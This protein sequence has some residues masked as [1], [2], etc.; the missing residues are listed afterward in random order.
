M[1]RAR[2]LTGMTALIT[3]LGPGPRVGYAPRMREEADEGLMSRYAAGDARAFEALYDRWRGPLY[4]YF[5]RHVSTDGTAADLYQGCWEKVINAR[6]R[7]RPEIPFR[8]WLFR[9]A[10]NHL[11]DHYRKGKPEI[12]LDAE[13]VAASDD[14]PEQRMEED[15][16][17]R[18]LRA[19]VAALPEE[20][21][22]AVLLK[23]EGGLALDDIASAMGVGRETAKSRLRYATRKLKE[24]L[25]DEHR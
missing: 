5:L 8:A 15:Q 23:L 16:R 9:V 18:R 11:V 17:T 12:P 14:A 3:A 7:Y 6:T 21:R 19:A 25:A 10:H 22:D 24:V 2:V 4:R 13:P 1:R 20:Q